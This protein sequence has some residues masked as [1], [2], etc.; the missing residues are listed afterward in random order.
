VNLLKFLGS[1]FWR[2]FVAT[3]DEPAIDFVREEDNMLGVVNGEE[4]RSG[5]RSDTLQ[6]L[7][8]QLEG[9]GNV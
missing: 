7:G 4:E 8:D 9:T 6:W 5:S 1:V 3:G 2:D